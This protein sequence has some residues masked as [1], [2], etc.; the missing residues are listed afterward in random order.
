[1]IGNGQPLPDRDGP[2]GIKT[3]VMLSAVVGS[4]MRGHRDCHHL[5]QHHTMHRTVQVGRSVAVP[6]VNG[7]TTRWRSPDGA[8]LASEAGEQVFRLE[9]PP[10]SEVCPRNRFRGAGFEVA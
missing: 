5:Q 4:T 3:Q 2:V 1:M 9:I 8:T 6:L 10:F 7:A